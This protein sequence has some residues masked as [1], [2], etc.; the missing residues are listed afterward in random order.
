MTAITINARVCLMGGM[1]YP[2]TESPWGL[3]QLKS[4]LEAIGV[5]VLLTGWADRQ[6]CDDFLKGFT[7]FKAL[8]GD[9]LGAGSAAQYAG[10]IDGPINFVAGFQPSMDDQRAVKGLITV[11]P[12]VVRAHCIYDPVWIDTLG[13]GQASYVI[14]EGSKTVLLQTQM[15]GMHPFDWGIPQDIIFNEIKGLIGAH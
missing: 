2:V 8:G 13:L 11:P 15:R 6:S 14:P 1:G 5:Q 7:G 10:D 12:N 3:P 4:R 9:S